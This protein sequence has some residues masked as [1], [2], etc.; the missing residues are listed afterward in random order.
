MLQLNNA[1]SKE[2]CTVF[3]NLQ[4]AWRAAVITLASRSSDLPVTWGICVYS[5]IC[6]GGYIYTHMY[7]FLHPFLNYLI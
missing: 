6:G 1:S 5:H 4:V 3:L 7:S 2:A